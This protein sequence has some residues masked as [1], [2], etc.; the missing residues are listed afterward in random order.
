M[1]GSS[2][3]AMTLARVNRASEASATGAMELESASMDSR[4]AP[5]AV[6]TKT[7][8]P[9]LGR[10]ARTLS[11]AVTSNSARRDSLRA[12]A[13]LVSGMNVRAM[14]STGAAAAVAMAR[15]VSRDSKIPTP[16]SVRLC[17]NTPSDDMNSDDGRSI[18]DVLVLHSVRRTVRPSTSVSAVP[19]RTLSTCTASGPLSGS[20]VV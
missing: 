20:S 17:T 2:L 19:L 8:D 7:C 11:L 16:R 15:V 18:S 9:A 1:A 13:L 10:S 4:A 6:R 3:S 14:I 5:A 12:R